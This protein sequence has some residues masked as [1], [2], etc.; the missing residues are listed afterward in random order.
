M[1]NLAIT[2]F[3][4]AALLVAGPGGIRA[5]E[6]PLPDQPLLFAAD[7]ALELTL[8]TDLRTVIRDIDSLDRQEHPATVTYQGADGA[9]V[10]LEIEVRTRG[11]YRRQR[12]N[13]NFPPLRLDFKT[14]DAEGTVFEGQDKVKLVT[15]CQ[16]GR[17]QY[18]QYV[19]LEEAVYRTL[20]VLTD[21]SLKTRLVRMTYVDTE[22]REDTLTR[23]GFIIES[24]EHAAER[25]GGV[26]L[27]VPGLHPLDADPDYMVLVDVFQYMMGNTDWSVPGVHNMM[28]MEADLAYYAVPYDFDWTGMVD[29]RYARPDERL[30]IRR[31]RDRLFRGMCRP[32]ERF[33]MTF[34]YFNL[35][36]DEIYAVYLQ[37]P[38]IEDD[39]RDRAV[40]YLD[41]FFETI[42]DE[43]R[44][45]REIINSCARAE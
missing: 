29:A 8:T 17:D 4:V 20:N 28:I 18:E 41:E 5:Q 31:V 26:W 22:A 11:H 38:G 21:M 12:R 13:C 42:N 36:R 27:N 15:H 23:W 39:V 24:E 43:G 25:I 14:K 10:T 44:A 33:Q 6:S 3:S 9:M 45:R 1:N 16:S 7:E 30:P 37:Q 35:K 19:L 40:E 2:T 34:D 32:P